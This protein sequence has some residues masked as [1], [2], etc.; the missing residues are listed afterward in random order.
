MG[1]GRWIQVI[2]LVLH[3]LQSAAFVPAT[4]W[5]LCARRA[6]TNTTCL[7]VLCL[8]HRGGSASERSDLTRQLQELQECLKETA[9]TLHYVADR[10][11]K[12]EDALEKGQPFVTYKG[13]GLRKHW[14]S[15]LRREERLLQRDADLRKAQKALQAELDGEALTTSTARLELR[16]FWL[17]LPQA[18]IDKH[19]ILKLPGNMT[20]LGDPGRKDR[21]YVRSCYTE[22]YD[23]I[24]ELNAA[25]VNRDPRV[26]ITGTPGAG[27]SQFA[28]YC[29]WRLSQE[30]KTVL[31]QVANKYYYFSGNI[32]EV[33]VGSPRASWL[34]NPASPEGTALWQ[35]DSIG[36][37][38]CFMS[39][40]IKRFQGFE[41]GGGD[42]NA[43]RRYMPI[44]SVNEIIR[45]Y[46]R[47]PHFRRH[48]RRLVLQR[49]AEWGPL[50]RYVLQYADKPEQQS[51]LADACRDVARSGV[52]EMLQAAGP[53]P[54]N[55]RFVDKVF[56]MRVDSD[57]RQY[58]LQWTSEYVEFEVTQGQR[59]LRAEQIDEIIN[60]ALEAPQ[61]GVIAGKM[62]EKRVHNYISGGGADM[63]CY[64]LNADKSRTVASNLVFKPICSQGFSDIDSMGLIEPGVYYVP[65]SKTFHAA[66]SFAVVEDTAFMFQ[67]SINLL[68]SA[69]VTGLWTIRKTCPGVSRFVV[70]VM[71]PPRA[72]AMQ[73]RDWQ[74]QNGTAIP[75]ALMPTNLTN[76]E[77]WVATMP[78]TATTTM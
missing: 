34:E 47:L 9:N 72:E 8:R 32:V 44:W 38:V 46:A 22:L 69:K 45:C 56:H 23:E 50:P 33:A 54:G 24:K 59:R 25:G 40:N 5:G 17:S 70:W 75:K 13:A 20:F 6:L 74:Y 11:R 1:L 16:N 4:S 60:M 68:H 78:L 41:K 67:T 57:Y 37:T 19:G 12:A 53:K 27:K 48:S 14:D 66:D 26:V 43:A 61:F 58:V 64:Y 71:P 3:G 21:L 31:L 51:K 7:P 55:K 63:T 76:Y 29:L 42:R 28:F 35:E 77:Q 18:Q 49:L 39:P 15:L 73:W 2:F 52:L 62:F 65:D 30:G 36:T 10:I